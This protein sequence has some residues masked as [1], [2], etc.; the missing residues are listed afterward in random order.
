MDNLTDSLTG[1]L[2]YISSTLSIFVARV[3]LVKLC[4][5]LEKL[6]S[7]VA[8]S[9]EAFSTHVISVACLHRASV[10]ALILYL[11]ALILYLE[12]P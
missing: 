8:P 11:D 2:Q 9:L 3:E 1:R 7:A 5:V 6:I 12:E 4:Y 10:D